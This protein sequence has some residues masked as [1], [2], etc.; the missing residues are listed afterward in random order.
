MDI[1]SSRGSPFIVS[2]NPLSS[3]VFSKRALNLTIVPIISVWSVRNASESLSIRLVTAARS[4]ILEKKSGSGSTN[5]WGDQI[6]VP[7]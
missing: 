3:F 6:I 4:A 1:T 5:P 2:R 7:R